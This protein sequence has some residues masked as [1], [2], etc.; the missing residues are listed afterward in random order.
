VLECEV[1][2]SPPHLLGPLLER[3]LAEGAHDAFF[4]P[5][6][7][8]KGRPGV[9]VTVIA[10][11]D[12]RLALEEVLFAETTTIGMRRTEWDRTVLERESVEVATPYGTVRMKLARRGGRLV[13]AA[14]EFED[15]LR[16]A[17]ERAVPVKEVWAAALA[18]HRAG[19]E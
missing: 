19:R 6:Q 3:L 14:P 18:A 10:P 2:D 9:L 12:R 15:C 17:R 5:V 11:P 1:D 7:M 16:A 4:T 8:K 13:N